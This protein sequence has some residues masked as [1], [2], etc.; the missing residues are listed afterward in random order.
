MNYVEIHQRLQASTQHTLQT[1]KGKIIPEAEAMLADET[2]KADSLL[3]SPEWQTMTLP[4]QKQAARVAKMQVLNAKSNLSK[5]KRE[6][7]RL[8]KT[9][10]EHYS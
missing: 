5:A 9:V 4:E 8:K 6:H 2:Q 1:L 3:G 7:A 10:E